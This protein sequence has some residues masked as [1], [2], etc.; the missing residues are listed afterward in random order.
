MSLQSCGKKHNLY[1]LQEKWEVQTRH[2]HWYTKFRLLALHSQDSNT[3][4]KNPCHILREKE[5][6]VSEITSVIKIIYFKNNLKNKKQNKTKKQPT[7][8][9]KQQ[10]RQPE[11]DT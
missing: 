7:K 8:Q 10:A 11:N 3:S 4:T 9:K 6:K 2:P 1:G 5:H